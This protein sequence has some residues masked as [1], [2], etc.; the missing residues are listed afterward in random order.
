MNHLLQLA[1]AF[2]DEQLQRH[3]NIK[4]VL[5]VGSV[6]RD[7]ATP[8][9]DIDLRFL[10][11]GETEHLSRIDGWCEG[12][13]ID[14]TPEPFE[15]YSSLESILSYPIRANDMNSGHILHDPENIL[16]TLQSQVRQHFMEHTWVSQ[17]VKRIAERIPPGLRS[18]E[19]AISNCNSLA[20]CHYA[21]RLSFH[22]AL[23]PLIQQGVSP[24]STRHLAQL[25]NVAPD[26]QRRIHDFEGSTHMTV[27]N[28]L[29][30]TN[31]VE[32]WGVSYQNKKQSDL[33]TYMLEKARWMA[34]N[35]LHKEAVHALWINVSFK[36]FDCLNAEAQSVQQ[37]GALF[38]LEWLQALGWQDALT[39]KQKLN[40][41]K[42]I[43][44][45]VKTSAIGFL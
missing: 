21:G 10:I 8:F 29:S 5:L 6:A 14:G 11:K 41:A 3:K 24:S 30:L 35:H 12:V 32:H 31:V 22:L 44:Q 39:L 45:D 9:S 1:R 33:G 18:L 13:Y 4:G 38:A 42:E 15:L 25:G 28:G 40:L 20:L 23:L 34:N 27:A 37:N 43:W 2:T 17:R 26:L 16:N 36:A 19:Q 7:D